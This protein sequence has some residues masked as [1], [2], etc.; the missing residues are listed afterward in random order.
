MKKKN[1]VT[2]IMST[3]GGI[4]FALGMCMSAEKWTENLPLFLTVRQSEQRF[5]ASSVQSF[6]VLGCA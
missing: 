6:W 4:L 1:F 3:V 5:L 2:L